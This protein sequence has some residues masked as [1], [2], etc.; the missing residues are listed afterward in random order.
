MYFPL[1]ILFSAATLVYYYRRR[2]REQPTAQAA[3]APPPQSQTRSN[4]VPSVV[5]SIVK[6]GS[7]AQ[8]L[9]S[10]AYEV[11]EDQKTAFINT[12]TLPADI[13]FR[14]SPEIPPP[15]RVL[16]NEPNEHWSGQLDVDRDI[17]IRVRDYSPSP[18]EGGDYDP[19][20]FSALIVANTAGHNN[21]MRVYVEP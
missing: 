10:T 5:L 9:P 3:S 15:A 1:A 2:Q 6:V 18:S 17:S 19:N 7:D 4:P 12:P 13:I 20:A 16:F 14:V 21:D 11:S 8:F